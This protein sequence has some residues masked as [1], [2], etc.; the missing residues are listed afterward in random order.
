MDWDIRRDNPCGLAY[1]Q[2][3]WQVWTHPDGDS[4][5]RYWVRLQ[6]VREATKIIEQLFDG[7]PSGP[8]MAKVPRIIKVPAGEA[9]VETENPLGAMGYY[10]VSKGD[11]VPF[12]VKI[13]SASFSNLSIAPWLLKGVY[14]PRHHHHPRQPL[15][16]TGGHR[17]MIAGIFAELAYWQQTVIKAGVVA[18][19]IPTAALI[20]GY[21]FLLKMMSFV[22]SRL[23]P[24]EAGPHGTLQLLADGLKFLQ[25]ER[26]L[27]REVRQVRLCGGSS[28]GAGEHLFAVCGA[29]CGAGCRRERLGRRSVLRSGRVFAFGGG[30]FDGG[31]GFGQQIRPHR[32][33][34][35]CR[36]ADCL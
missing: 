36:A 10:I 24:M 20:L 23:G 8:I 21:V 30:D 27:P 3:D 2:L 17:Q 14:V 25:K 13:R 16:H 19:V 28:D 32:R 22:Q 12:R 11:L 35:G 9:Y 31:L 33:A 7:L 1:D 29:A 6:E 15:F 18:A 5:A 4:F 26:H 34:A